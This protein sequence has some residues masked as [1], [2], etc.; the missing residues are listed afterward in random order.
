VRRVFVCGGAGVAGAVAWYTMSANS[1]NVMMWTLVQY[2]Q[3]CPIRIS[4][5]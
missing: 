2:S 3:T 1:R 4:S 5:L